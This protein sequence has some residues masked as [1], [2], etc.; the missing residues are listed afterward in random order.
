MKQN[1][2]RVNEMERTEMKISKVRLSCNSRQGIVSDTIDNYN[3]SIVIV[4]DRSL[5]PNY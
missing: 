4:S 1:G 3:Y 2:K 5:G